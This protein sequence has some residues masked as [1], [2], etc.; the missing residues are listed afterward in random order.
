MDPRSSYLC[1]CMCECYMCMSVFLSLL[2]F[3]TGSLKILPQTSQW[4]SLGEILFYWCP[5]KRKGVTLNKW[6]GLLLDQ[7]VFARTEPEV[8][9]CRGLSWV[10]PEFLLFNL[11][12][13]S[14]HRLSCSGWACS[15]LCPLAPYLCISLLPSCCLNTRMPTRPEPCSLMRSTPASA[16]EVRASLADQTMSPSVG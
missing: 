7:P 5:E 10:M 2:W 11:L 1:V 12:M 9:C 15:G 14:F 8:P 4:T 16:R 6:T 13:P 3:L